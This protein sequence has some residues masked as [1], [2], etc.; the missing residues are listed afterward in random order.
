MIKKVM[1]IVLSFLVF[2]TLFVIWNERART[3]PMDNDEFYTQISSVENMPWKNMWVGRIDEGNNAPLFYAIQKLY[4]QVLG[5]H[6]PDAWKKGQWGYQ[7]PRSKFVMRLIPVLCMAGG[8]TLI[9]FFTTMRLG[10]IAGFY[11]LIICGTSYMVWAYACI[12]RPYSLW[13]FLTSLQMVL[14]LFWLEAKQNRK[15]QIIKGLI[16]SHWLLSITV[17]FS[18]ITNIAVSVILWQNGMRKIKYHVLLLLV[19]TVSSLFYYFHAP[20]YQFF[21]KNGAMKLLG[22]NLAVDRMFIIACALFFWFLAQ[23]HSLK[24]WFHPITPSGHLQFGTIIGFGVMVLAGCVAVYLKLKMGQSLHAEG[25]EVSNRYFMLLTPIGIMM[26]IAASYYMVTLS[27]DKILKQGV[28]I[29]LL[30]LLLF[31][32]LKLWA[33]MP[34]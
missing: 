22:A 15:E 24:K 20:Q 1:V 2:L 19:P 34:K 29:F 3:H 10:F 17:V 7:H 5:Y 18:V 13:F 23:R 27:K 11:A 21:I 9:F 12:A 31:R 32:I 14:L 28:L 16:V 26:T 4:Q 8:V 6:S 33:L 30:V 25:F